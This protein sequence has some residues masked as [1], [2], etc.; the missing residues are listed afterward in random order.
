MIVTFCIA[1][2]SSRAMRLVVLVPCHLASLSVGEHILFGLS[3]EK[4]PC[5]LSACSLHSAIG[6]LYIY[7]YCVCGA[8]MFLA[9]W[10]SGHMGLVVTL[11]LGVI[12]RGGVINGETGFFVG[13][14]TLA[15]VLVLPVIILVCLFLYLW[16]WYHNS[17]PMKSR[18][19]IPSWLQ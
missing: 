4:K 2:C 16:V 17:T 12:R 19:G 15:G 10:P 3:W 14:A 11:V 5:S 1:C 6:H 18:L 9:S 7:L 8:I 13:D